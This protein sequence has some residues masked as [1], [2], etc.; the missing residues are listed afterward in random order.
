MWAQTLML[1]MV[2]FGLPGPMGAMR[3]YPDMVGKLSGSRMVQKFC[4]ASVWLRGPVSDDD[5]N[6]NDP[7][8]ISMVVRSS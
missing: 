1:A 6:P 4:L 7:A 5:T 3:N 2:A 8:M